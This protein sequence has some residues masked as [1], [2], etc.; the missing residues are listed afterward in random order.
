MVLNDLITQG[1]GSGIDWRQIASQ[2][3]GQGYNADQ[4][5]GAVQGMN[6]GLYAQGA[7]FAPAAATGDFSDPRW[8]SL[9]DMSTAA[10]G[11]FGT[12][13]PSQIEQ[14]PTM[15]QR[16]PMQYEGGG[17]GLANPYAPGMADDLTRRSENYLGRALQSIRGQSVGV[18]GLGGSR[19]GV[20]EA[21]AIKGG[22][23]NLLGQLTGM[24]GGLYESDQN[25]GVTKRGQDMSFYST[26]RGQDLTQQG[27]GFDMVDR[28]YRGGWLPVQN[29]GS[30][31][32]QFT[33][34]GPQT[35]S[36]QQGGG[37]MGVLGGALGMAQLGNAM[38]WFGGGR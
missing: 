27:M 6:P 18:G 5:V 24:Y 28:A 7:D 1:L 12:L 8:K 38:G 3:H 36:A 19:Q 31:Y 37:S 25:R 10:R 2:A 14:P 9:N 4:F 33:G 30:I 13:S 20:A 35:S 15:P 16:S 17:A 23:D 34:Y 26:Q 22:Q 29:A 21:E 32:G 11:Y